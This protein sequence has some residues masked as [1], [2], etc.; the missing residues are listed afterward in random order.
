MTMIGVRP[1]TRRRF[2]ALLVS[3]LV[4]A[5]GSVGSATAAADRAGTRPGDG[6]GVLRAAAAAAAAAAPSGVDRATYQAAVEAYIWGYPLVVM[7]RTRAALVCAAGVNQFINQPSLAGP[8]SRVVVTPNTDTLYS[9]AWLDLRSG[10]VVLRVPAVAGRYYVFQLLDMYTNTITNVGSRTIGEGPASVAFARS[11]WRGPLPAG[12][13]RINSPTPDVW[14]IGRTL[15]RN[16]ADVANVAALQRE[17]AL[18]P[19]GRNA[20]PSGAARARCSASPAAGASGA[21]F[22]DELGAALAADPPPAS[23][24]PV[25]RDLGAAGIGV[26]MSPSAK[27]A[28]AASAALSQS[29]RAANGMIAAAA[30]HGLRSVNGWSQS[31]DIGAYGGD[32][33]TRAAIAETALG[34]NVPAESV[35][36]FAGADVGGV[37]LVGTRPVVVH[38][39]AGQVPPIDRPGFWSLTLY[40]PDHFLVANPVDR[41]AIGDR[42]AGLQR[43]ADGSLDLYLSAEPPTGH[44]TN[45]IPAPPGPFSLVLRAY[46]PGA[47]IRRGTWHPPTIR[48]QLP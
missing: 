36:Y 4:V 12:V 14:V 16:V 25:L 41:Y 38:F 26:G 32:Y 10:P 17:Y 45:W 7:A 11:N 1:R 24:R 39:A 43:S 44:E 30:A 22:F 42:T 20:S 40:G 6:L 35:Y 13:K 29:I 21:G 37:S 23:D 28:P 19:V 48:P 46:L 47:P 2:G 15:P 18:A 31:R 34:A 33:L 9:S 27:A 5:T 8:S 3:V